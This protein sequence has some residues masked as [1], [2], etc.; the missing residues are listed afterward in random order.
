MGRRWLCEVGV[1]GWRKLGRFRPT[2]RNRRRGGGRRPAATSFQIG[3]KLRWRNKSCGMERGRIHRPVR[4]PR[5][6]G[7]HPASCG[8]W[9]RNRTFAT[10]SHEGVL[11][12][13]TER[14]G[15]TAQ[16]ARPVRTAA[17]PQVAAGG[18]ATGP[19][20]ARMRAYELSGRRTGSQ[21]LLWPMGG[22]V[23]AGKAL[24]KLGGDLGAEGRGYAL[25]VLT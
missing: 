12:E 24:H 4:A 6:D 7:R 20:P 16:S 2:P 5:A 17:T 3:C 8:G 15:S 21:H 14:L 22:D 18:D 1:A 10:R 13:Q 11:T 19:S 9:W 23:C 25:H